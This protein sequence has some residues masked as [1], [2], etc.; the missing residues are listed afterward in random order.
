MCSRYL[1]N[2]PQ[3]DEISFR[4]WSSNISGSFHQI[5][6]SNSTF[7]LFCIFFSGYKQYPDT[8]G[9]GNFWK[10]GNFYPRIFTKSRGLG[11]FYPWVFLRL[12]IFRGWGFFSSWDGISHQKATSA[13]SWTFLSVF[14]HPIDDTKFWWTLKFGTFGS[15]SAE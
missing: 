3:I 4:F 1:L 5:L 15:F 13:I 14:W 12:E 9:I 11:I 7:E 6:I 2:K 8:P 10:S